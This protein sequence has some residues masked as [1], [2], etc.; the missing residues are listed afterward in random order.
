MA[1]F[2]LCGS[3]RQMPRRAGHERGPPARTVTAATSPLTV[4]DARTARVRCASSDVAAL[5]ASRGSLIGS[6]RHCGANTFAVSLGASQRQE[7]SGENGFGGVPRAGTKRERGPRMDAVPLQTP[8]YWQRNKERCRAA[9]VDAS[10]RA[11]G[12]L[13]RLLFGPSRVAP[14]ALETDSDQP[15]LAQPCSHC[16]FHVK[17]CRRDHR[18][19]RSLARHL[20]RQRP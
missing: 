11:W 6:N 7:A 19:L 17:H 18:S 15:A 14:C 9:T 3:H 2:C 10:S 5:G 12:R 16:S 13:S 20:L 4:V 8:G 1:A